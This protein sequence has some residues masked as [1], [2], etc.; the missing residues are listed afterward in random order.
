MDCLVQLDLRWISRL[1]Q[2]LPGPVHR[3]AKSC[4]KNLV[5]YRNFGGDAGQ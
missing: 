5:V 3:L 1:R 2:Q 4:V